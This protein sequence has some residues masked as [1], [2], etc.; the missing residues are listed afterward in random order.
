MRKIKYWGHKYK[1]TKAGWIVIDWNDKNTLPPSGT[2][3]C[4]LYI[5]FRPKFDDEAILIDEASFGYE[6]FIVDPDDYI[7]EDDK[8]SDKQSFWGYDVKNSRYYRYEDASVLAWMPEP[9]IDF[10]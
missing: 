7:S 10:V 2:N 5:A 8:Q 1:I 3:M 6:P 9:K 4:G